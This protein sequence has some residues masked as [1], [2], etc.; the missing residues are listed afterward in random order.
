MCRGDTETSGQAALVF[1]RGGSGEVSAVTRDLEIGAMSVL[2]F[3]VS[4][5]YYFKSHL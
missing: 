4:S 3:D 2:Q 1:R 5:L